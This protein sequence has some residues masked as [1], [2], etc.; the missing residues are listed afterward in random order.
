[1]AARNGGRAR[2][3]SQLEAANATVA[4]S[5]SHVVGT[6]DN[7]D[8]FGLQ[9]LSDGGRDVLVLAG[10]QPR[11]PLDDGDRSTETTVHLGELQRDVAAA[12]DDQ[13]LWQR[14]EFEDGNVGQEIDVGKPRD[15][16]SHRA[17]TDVE[18]YPVRTQQVVTDPQGVRILESGVPAEHGAAVYAVQPILDTLTVGEH[19]AVFACLDFGHVHTDGAGTDTVFGATTGQLRGVRTGDQRLGR[20]T[21]G[22]HAGTADMFALHD[23]NALARGGQPTH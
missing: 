3:G 21:P 18:E 22:V 5:D 12:D 8:A 16:R 6:N 20:D 1:M 9:D 19:D 10:S 17:A 13:M 15:V 7:V 23:R 14:V 4:L 2:A 11:S